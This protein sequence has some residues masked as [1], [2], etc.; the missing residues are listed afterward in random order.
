[1]STRSQRVELPSFLLSSIFCTSY[2]IFLIEVYN[3]SLARYCTTWESAQ[4]FVNSIKVEHPKA[5]HICFAFVGGY[6]PKTERCSDDG[7]PTGTAG[8]PILGGINGEEL[9]DTVCAVVR[10]SGGIKLGAG[11][12]IRAYGGT[13]RMALRA[14]EKII[15]IPKSSIRINTPSSN[16]GQV[17]AMATKYKGSVGEETYNDQGDLGVTITCDTADAE[18]IRQSLTDATRG[19]IMFLDE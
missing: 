11:G 6:N 7:E 15:L 10:Y 9:S 3:N 12:L 17:Y 4:E 1:M 16:A 2:I 5:R 13:A 8:V 18:A 19:N 14:A